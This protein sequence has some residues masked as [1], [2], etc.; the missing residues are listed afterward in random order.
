MTGPD[1]LG[2]LPRRARL[3]ALLARARLIDVDTWRHLDAINAGLLAANVALLDRVLREWCELRSPLDGEGP[4]LAPLAFDE[5][6]VVFEQQAIEAYLSANALAPAARRAIDVLLAWCGNPLVRWLFGIDCEL[7][8]A[9]REHR[10]AA[11]RRLSFFALETR[12][13]IGQRLVRRLHGAG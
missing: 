3:A 2:A 13:A 6:M 12:I 11:R 7:C 5:A 1:A 9:V 8:A 10:R 4:A